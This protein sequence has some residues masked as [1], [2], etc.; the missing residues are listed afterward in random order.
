MFPSLRIIVINNQI[1][2][3]RSC[4]LLRSTNAYLFSGPANYYDQP[5][6]TCSQV[7]RIITINQR[8]PVLRSCE[9]LRSTNAYLFSGPANYYDQSTHTCSQV[10]GVCNDMSDYAPDLHVHFRR[11]FYFRVLAVS[12]YEPA[13]MIVLPNKLHSK[14]AVQNRDDDIS[15]HSSKRPVDQ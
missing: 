5:T 10:L 1:H 13:G 8:I 3:L 15:I 11:D 4:E 9:L 12:G 2:V 7:P 6:H 14:L